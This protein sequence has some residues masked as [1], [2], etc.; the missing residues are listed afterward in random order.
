MKLMSAPGMAALCHSLYNAADFCLGV[1]SYRGLLRGGTSGPCLACCPVDLWAFGG[2]MK[3]V[4]LLVA[5]LGGASAFAADQTVLDNYKKTC[6][7]CHASGAGN[8]PRTGTADWD[9]RMSKGLDSL[10]ESVKTGFGG[11]MP[12]KGMCFNCSDDDL[13]N[14]IQYMA[15]G[16]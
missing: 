6:G 14:L 2:I 5:L 9:A 1:L 8:A 3:Y 16:Q 12:P 11:K 7:L 15:T 4:L 10:L 13:K